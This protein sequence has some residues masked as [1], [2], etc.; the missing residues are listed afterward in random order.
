M[1]DP[2]PDGWRE[3]LAGERL[4]ETPTVEWIEPPSTEQAEESRG[5]G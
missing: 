1:T 4:S 2:I 5:V 3:T